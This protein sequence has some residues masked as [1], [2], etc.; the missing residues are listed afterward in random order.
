[1][2]QEVCSTTHKN[3]FSKMNFSNT[4]NITTTQ[5]GV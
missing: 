5:A 1:M 2:N 3:N 4:G